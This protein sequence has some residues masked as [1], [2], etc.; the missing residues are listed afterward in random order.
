MFSFN[1]I[2]VMEFANMALIIMILSF[3]PELSNL[4]RGMSN[5]D[6]GATKKYRGFEPDWYSTYANKIGFFIFLSFV[7]STSIDIFYA[8]Y[9][10]I[11]RLHDR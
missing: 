8:L 10:T 1:M 9:I 2:L 4:M 7:F 11:L 6:Y 5:E 3:E